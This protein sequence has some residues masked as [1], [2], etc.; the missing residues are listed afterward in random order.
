MKSSL[1]NIED[2][3]LFTWENNCC[4]IHP[5]TFHHDADRF[6]NRTCLHRDYGSIDHC[7]RNYMAN[8]FA[9]ICRNR[10]IGATLLWM[11]LY[12]Q[13]FLEDTFGFKPYQ[14]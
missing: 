4:F 2:R 12:A 5:V 11:A 14:V 10:D 9:H 13:E 1:K 3:F 7:F 6:R 8:H